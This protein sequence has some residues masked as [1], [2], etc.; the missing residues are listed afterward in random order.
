MPEAALK[1]PRLITPEIPWRFRSFSD[2]SALPEEGIG[3]DLKGK[4]AVVVE[5]EGVTQLQLRRM[6]RSRG[7][8]VVGV[9]ANGQEAIEVVLRHK[10]DFVLMDIQMPVMN[11]LEASRRILEQYPVCIVMLTAFSEEEYLQEAQEI[12]VSGYVLKPV[13]T[14]TLLPPLTAAL[15]KFQ[16]QH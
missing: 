9:A 6:L 12:G 16:K 5:D 14:E 2:E 8:A 10:P 4:R 11:G 15:Q 1:R 13:T 3:V 7:V